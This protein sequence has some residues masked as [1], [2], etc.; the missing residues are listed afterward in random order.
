VVAVA[1]ANDAAVSV[2]ST[3]GLLLSLKTGGE[4]AG[5]G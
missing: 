2:N 4:V 3:V 1:A 5:K